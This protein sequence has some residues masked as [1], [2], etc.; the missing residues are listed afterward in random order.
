MQHANPDRPKIIA[1][2]I[3]YKAVKTL[4]KFYTEFPKNLVDEII[5]VD[6][7]SGDGTYELSKK[8]GITSFENP[9]NLGYG[10]NM[11]RALEIAMARGANVI[12]DIHPDGEYKP[13]AIPA[14][15]DQV[16]RGAGLVLGNRF[17]TIT[18][19]LE[20][21]MYSWKIIPILTLNIFDRLVLGVRV[22]DLHQG[23]RV[24]TRKLLEQINYKA[25]TNGYLF[26][27]ELIA[28]AAFKKITIA[29]VPVETNYTGEKRGASLKNSLKYSFAT[30]KVLVLFFAAK[31]GIV[32][33]IFKVP[34]K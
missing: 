11:K 8:L 22:H 30:F 10:G 4:E 24:Y 27:F 18:K 14:A 20:S 5:L 9:V 25:N 1:I 12:I 33:E 32:S 19:P 34:A 3:A 15:L 7:A 6:D 29:E 13:S 21:G 2:F 31:L 23:F 26:S 16:K 17:T 28:Q